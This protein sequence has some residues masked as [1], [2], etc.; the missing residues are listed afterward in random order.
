[1]TLINF[2]LSLVSEGGT[3]LIAAATAIGSLVAVFFSIKHSA[4]KEVRDGIRAEAYKKSL[5]S[6]QEREAIESNTDR[7]NDDELDR[8][9]DQYTGK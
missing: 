4:K 5:K 8:L 2:L 3:V 9:L 1:M 6:M 7:L